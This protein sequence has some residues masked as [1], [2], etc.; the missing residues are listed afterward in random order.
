MYVT[1]TKTNATCCRKE[2]TNILSPVN[3]DVDWMDPAFTK[4]LPI[5]PHDMTSNQLWVDIQMDHPDN[6]ELV[7]TAVREYKDEGWLAVYTRIV[8]ISTP[9]TS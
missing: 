1:Q 9:A 5:V 7:R 6:T 8:Y 3:I 4:S 2:L